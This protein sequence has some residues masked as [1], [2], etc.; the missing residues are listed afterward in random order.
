[1]MTASTSKWEGLGVVVGYLGAAMGEVWSSSRR[2]LVQQWEGLAETV[3]GPMISSPPHSELLVYFVVSMFKMLYKG[4]CGPPL[5]K[6]P[7]M[8]SC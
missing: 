1:M 2:S 7:C 6:I 3:G 8:K 5:N 4:G